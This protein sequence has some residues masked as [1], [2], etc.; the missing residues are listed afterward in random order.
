M[1]VAK[2]R[3]RHGLGFTLLRSTLQ[4]P[5]GIEAGG[6][7]TI[8]VVAIA[9]DVVVV[10]ISAF[11]NPSSVSLAPVLF[12]VRADTV[13]PPVLPVPNPEL[14]HECPVVGFVACF[15]LPEVGAAAADEL[16]VGDVG[17]A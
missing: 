1:K 13:V 12:L 8:I 17:S 10:L 14:L 6:S 7:T 3:H 2:A 15:E 5:S 4:F 16:V 11:S 9:V